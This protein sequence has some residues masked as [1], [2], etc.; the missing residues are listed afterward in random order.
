MLKHFQENKSYRMMRRMAMRT[1]FMAL[2]IYFGFRGLNLME[3]MGQADRFS[4]VRE[5]PEFM[6]II[7]AAALYASIEL[8]IFWIRLVISPE[9]DH[10]RPINLAMESPMAAAVVNATNVAQWFAR[11]CIFI[12]LMGAVS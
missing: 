9:N 5:Y 7:K 4:L 10:Q 3:T 6:Q 1:A 12:H 8:W 11:V 2:L